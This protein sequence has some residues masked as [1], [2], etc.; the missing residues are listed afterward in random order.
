MKLFNS[1]LVHIHRRV[2]ALAAVALLGS[3][4]S[5]GAG[6]LADAADTS[7]R[8]TAPSAP[9]ELTVDARVNPIAVQG[10]PQFGWLPRDHDG[11]EIQTAYELALTRGAEVVW[12]SGKVASSGQSWVL[13]SGPKLDPGNTYE[14]T[15]RTWDRHGAVSPYAPKA[16]FDSGL[17]DTD[18]SGAQWIRR[19]TTGNDASN[20]W[21]LA[22]KVVSVAKTS[23]VVRARAYV[24]AMGDW[25]LNVNG[26]QIQRSSSYS[27][28]GEGYYDVAD[29][30]V[31]A[32]APLAVGVLYHYWNCKCQGRANGPNTPE[33]PSGLLAKIV[34]D[35][36]DGSREVVVSDGSWKVTRYAAQSIS[37]LTY[38]NGDAGD[39]V[40]D[41]DATHEMPGW[42]TTSYDDSSW[43]NATIIGPH[44]RPNAASCTGFEGSSS[45]CTFTHLTAQ[46]AHLAY[47]SVHPVSVKRL[48]DGTVFADFGK[49]YSAVPS[50]ELRNGVASRQ[51]TFTTSYRRNNSTL[52][53]AASAGSDTV[54]LASTANLHVGDEIVVDAPAN[55]YGAGDPESRTVVGVSDKVATL[56][57]S[58]ARAHASG[59]WVENSRS[60]TSPLDTQ[61]S[62]MRYF[63]TEQTGEQV[64]Q[65][66]T[67][68]GWRYLQISDPGEQLTADDITAVVQNTDAPADKAATFHS[69][70]AT[71][72]NVFELMQRSALQSEQNVF[73]DTPTRE[74]GQFLG[75]TVDESFASMAALRERSLTREAIIAFMESQDRYWA[76]GAMNAVYPNGDAKRDIPDYSEMFPEWVMR[77][78]QTTGDKVLLARAL[79]AMK[80]VAG[81]ISAAVD[82]RGLVY[83]LP[84]GSGPYQYGII[85]WPSPMR[86]DNVVSGNAAR[87]VVNAIG[88]GA[89]RSVAEAAKELDDPA[90]VATYGQ[91]ADALAK[92]MNSQ[93]RDPSTRRWSD[94]LAAADGSQIRNYSEHAQTYPIVYGV[95][96]EEDNAAL[97]GYI[98]SLGMR[99]GPMDL[100]QL[101]EA[102]RI[103]NRPDA[104]AKLLSDP[105]ADGPAKILA[106]GGT[107]MWEQWT[108]GCA[109]ASCTGSQVNQNNNESFS[110]GWGGAGVVG[111]L[112]GLLGVTV[113]GPGAATLQIAPPDKGLAHAR[114]TQW[115]E[116]GPV[117]VGWTRTGQGYVADVDLPVNVTATVALPVVEGSDYLTHG[118]GDA[119][120][121]RVEN[122]RALFRVGSGRTHFASTRTT[123]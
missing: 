99:Q 72:D 65:P 45:P 10:A 76:N 53:A 106:E 101:L 61:G 102:L 95:S 66:F 48:P 90:T 105:N 115:T 81:Y 88:V 94:G 60:G 91:R 7:A 28:P 100:R 109:V 117:T 33:G 43:A 2:A 58:L 64:A 123:R 78:Y 108:P 26:K 56:S 25:T 1:S 19:P 120:F 112:E 80:R 103:T 47:R 67:Y 17:E 82:S 40:E 23:P 24:A 32:G 6:S 35:H 122:G 52:T 119:S 98:A 50:V 55:G 96:P 97:G 22:R 104:I 44:P 93:L 59:T 92:A 79:P 85:D 89:L 38:R 86:Y 13:Y 30:P 77:Y 74:K 84:G 27:Y 116:R 113:T 36:A 71:L 62:N 49:V 16:T 70:N 63:Y 107:F 51:L 42:D 46:E 87:T 54:T 75:D 121:L 8:N 34:V 37:K 73:L 5:V 114:G 110:H 29:L 39:L 18:W 4:F 11:N 68:W 111:V 83:N 9:S 12:D 15:V 118:E 69:D 20:D 14:W 31:K 41:Y 21:T 3:A 57:R